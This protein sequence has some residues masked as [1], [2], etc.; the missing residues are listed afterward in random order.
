[1]DQ[2]FTPFP[3]TFI[4]TRFCRDGRRAVENQSLARSQTTPRP[5]T[6]SGREGLVQPTAALLHQAQAIIRLDMTIGASLAVQQ[7]E[8]LPSG[9]DVAMPR[10]CLFEKNVRVARA[11]NR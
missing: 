3:M 6:S 2:H 10:F 9:T 5:A 8:I 4:R 11:H 1:M 7:H